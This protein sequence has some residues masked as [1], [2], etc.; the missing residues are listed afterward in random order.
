VKPGGTRGLGPDQ[1]NIEITMEEMMKM[2][3]KGIQG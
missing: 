1:E 3:G 2:D